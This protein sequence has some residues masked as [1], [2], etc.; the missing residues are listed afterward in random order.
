MFQYYF[1]T[2]STQLYRIGL[3]ALLVESTAR[4]VRAITLQIQLRRFER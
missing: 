4:P 2:F 3:R 1:T